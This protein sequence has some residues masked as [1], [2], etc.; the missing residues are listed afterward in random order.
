MSDGILN[1]DEQNSIASIFSGSTPV[2]GESDKS[3]GKGVHN[4]PEAE[5]DAISNILSEAT[6]TW[7]ELSGRG[8]LEDSDEYKAFTTALK[9]AEVK[10][11]GASFDAPSK[12]APEDSVHAD[13]SIKQLLT[14]SVR[15]EDCAKFL[16][17]A[18]DHFSI[19][20]YPSGEKPNEEIDLS[21][22]TEDEDSITDF[23]LG[24][25][26]PQEPSLEDDGEYF[27]YLDE[28]RDSGVTNMLGAGAYLEKDF[29]ID[30]QE[31]RRVL[32][33]WME[34]F[35]DRHPRESITEQV[36]KGKDEN[37]DNS[38]EDI[39]CSNSID[40]TT[41]SLENPETQVVR[42]K[43]RVSERVVDFAIE[44]G[45]QAT[46]DRLFDYK[47]PMDKKSKRRKK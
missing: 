32:Q 31:A 26:A 33:R 38:I 46:L 37:K 19:V 11:K 45:T 30:P 34:T 2:K 3:K 5:V 7:I 18:Q 15:K 8:F 25:P 28:L 10:T 27:E 47:Q 14:I 22:L 41:N 43:L 42:K 21:S 29:S 35:S 39:L 40:G 1:E 20:F 9:E 36:D 24:K 4:L 12:E 6:E 13:T 16:Q 23:D 17:V 44:H